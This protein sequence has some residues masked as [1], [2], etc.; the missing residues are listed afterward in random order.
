[1]FTIVADEICGANYSIDLTDF[2]A[3]SQIIHVMNFQS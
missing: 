2:D 1:G 3:K